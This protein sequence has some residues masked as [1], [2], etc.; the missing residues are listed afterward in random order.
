MDWSEDDSVV[1]WAVGSVVCDGLTSSC[2]VVIMWK[3]LMGSLRA[4]SVV[5]IGV[6][7]FFSF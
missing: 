4:G 7:Q 1:T 5:T 3:V 6:S 2:F